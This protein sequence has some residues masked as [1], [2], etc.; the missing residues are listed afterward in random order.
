MFERNAAKE[1]SEP[2]SGED[3]MQSHKL[4]N[5]LCLVISSI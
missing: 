3:G 1:S 5:L 4:E 2:S